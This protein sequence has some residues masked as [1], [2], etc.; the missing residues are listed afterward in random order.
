MSDDSEGHRPVPPQGFGT[1]GQYPLPACPTEEH[2]DND[3]D[4]Q[5]VLEYGVTETKEVANPTTIAG[6]GLTK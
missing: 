4:S 2:A 1:L 3:D 5:A 6:Y